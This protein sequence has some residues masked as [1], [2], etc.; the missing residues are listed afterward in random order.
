MVRWGISAL[1][2]L[3]LGCG[4]DDTPAL[5]QKPQQDTQVVDTEDVVV[6]DAADVVDVEPPED[7]APDV[8]DVPEPPD[9]PDVPD[10]PPED[11]P[12]VPDTEDTQDIEEDA[13]P[14]DPPV[15]PWDCDTDL[16]EPPLEVETLTGFAKGEDF[17]FSADGVFVGNAGGNLIRKTLDGPQELWVPNVG[18][19]AGMAFLSDGALVVASVSSN[20]LWRFSPAGAKSTLLSGLSYPNGLDVD[21]SDFVFLAEQ[22]GGRLRKIDGVTGDFETL[23]SGMCN[24]N[25]VTFGPG[26]DR[27]YV[28]SFGC[29]TVHRLERTA[30][31]G[32]S[33]P[34]LHATS[35]VSL[36][37]PPGPCEGADAGSSC[38]TENG[39]SGGCLED[40]TCV[41][42]PDAPDPYVA[43]CSA[44]AA[45]DPCLLGT[46]G[47]IFGGTCIEVGTVVFCDV[48]GDLTSSCEGKFT[49]QGCVLLQL[50]YPGEGHCADNDGTLECEVGFGGSV[51]GQDGLDGINA[52]ACGFVYVT[53]YTTGVIY[54]VSPDGTDVKLAVELDSYW[55]PNMHWGP[56]VGGWDHTTLYVADRDE[57]RLFGLKVG[58]PGKQ[59]TDVLP[60][61]E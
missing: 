39:A 25:G 36:P 40:G 7:V 28:G 4:D 12:D 44:S 53:E 45:G 6:M 41:A 27:V 19:T 2:V 35:G 60:L 56:L 3:A 8:P 32:W 50:G 31:G 20:A 54:R 33:P 29:G 24:P 30:E 34:I 22:S 14:P 21:K 55:I 9:V 5:T 52:D 59:V 61:E 13:G 51:Q 43:A 11:V 47:T 37:A 16:L 38:I 26:Y 46:H 23:A 48:G 58:V 15:P 10:V 1:L 18:E 57:G 17:A 49:G 42:V